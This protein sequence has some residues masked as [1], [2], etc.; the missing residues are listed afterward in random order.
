MGKY[1]YENEFPLLQS[2]GLYASDILGDGNCLFNALSDQIFGDQH[3]HAEIRDRVV[4]YMRANKDHYAQFL[5]VLPG[6]AQRR[7]PKRK[8]AGA[9]SSVDL[10]APTQAEI[11]RQFENYLSTMGRG[12]TYGGNLEI[13]AFSAAYNTDVKI[14]QA[15]FAY[16]LSANGDDNGSRPV[17]HIAYHVSGSDLKTLFL[18]FPPPHI[19]T[20]C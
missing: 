2:L 14:Y 20:C 6:G 9:L 13:N 5:G 1:S 10:A 11:D 12:G 16:M 18:S 3:K 19:L 7:N 8:A 17:A 15:D 4:D